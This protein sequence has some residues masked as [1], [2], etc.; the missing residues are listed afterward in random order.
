MPRNV[1]D[2][3][4]KMHSHFDAGVNKTGF[5]LKHDRGGIVDIEFMVQ[6]QVRHAEAHPE[7]AAYTDNIRQ[8]DGLSQSG[9]ISIRDADVLKR[10]Y[11]RYRALIHEAI[12]AGRKGRVSVDVIESERRQVEAIWAHWMSN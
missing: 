4:E 10:S 1:V 9:C 6:Y 12:L 7:L 5:D 8:L 11:V 2:M 3:R